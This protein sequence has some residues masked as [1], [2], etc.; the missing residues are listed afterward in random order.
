[1]TVMVLLGMKVKL[2]DFGRIEADLSYRHREVESF[3]IF[4][5]L[6]YGQRREKITDPGVYPEVYP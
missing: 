3:L 6:L 2:W 1:M 5:S 4:R